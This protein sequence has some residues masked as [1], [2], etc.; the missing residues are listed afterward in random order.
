MTNEI[1][2]LVKN[3]PSLV[4]PG[5]S[6]QETVGALVKAVDYLAAA[7]QG[8]VEALKKARSTRWPD[9]SKAVDG[10]MQHVISVDNAAGYAELW[11]KGG[12]WY[13]VTGAELP[14]PSLKKAVTSNEPGGIYQI[15][16]ITKGMDIGH[17]TSRFASALFG[18]IPLKKGGCNCG[19][20][21]K[22]W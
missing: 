9:L 1:A 17:A 11:H 21:S 8:L 20:N 3:N 13:A 7:P 22:S 12:N 4:V 10:G 15:P 5:F 2:Q 14:G 6:Q 19:G 16:K 18:P